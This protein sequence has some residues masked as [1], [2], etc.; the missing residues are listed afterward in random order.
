MVSCGCLVVGGGL[1]AVGQPV[2]GRTAVQLSS[3]A[4]LESFGWFLVWFWYVFG[5]VF[6]RFD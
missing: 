2:G 6:D 5:T 1:W 3:L 4:V